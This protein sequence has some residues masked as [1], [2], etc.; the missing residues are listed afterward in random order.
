MLGQ[1][2]RWMHSEIV[3]ILRNFDSDCLKTTSYVK[4]GHLISHVTSAFRF[5][6]T[7]T[8]ALMLYELALEHSC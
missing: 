1:G 8:K 2:A 6:V 4:K 7:L 5:Q 3:K